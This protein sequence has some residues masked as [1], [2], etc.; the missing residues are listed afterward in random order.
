MNN[1]V[2]QKTDRLYRRRG[3]DAS[4]QLSSLMEP[5]NNF[6]WVARLL[7]Q[8]TTAPRP[9]KEDILTLVK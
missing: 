9:S 3:P 7:P 8:N 5:G 2:L 6:A 1:S 4:G